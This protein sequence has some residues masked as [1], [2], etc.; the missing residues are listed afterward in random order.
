MTDDEEEAVCDEN[1]RAPGEVAELDLPLDNLPDV[2][3]FPDNLG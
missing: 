3:V 1:V 2:D